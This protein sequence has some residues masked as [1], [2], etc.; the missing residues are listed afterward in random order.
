VGLVPLLTTALVPM[1]P[2]RGKGLGPGRGM[3]VG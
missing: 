2:E 1:L 3:S